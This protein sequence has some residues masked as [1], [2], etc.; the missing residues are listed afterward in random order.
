MIVCGGAIGSP[1]LLLLSGIGP[2]DDLRPLGIEVMADLP[3]V[4]ANLHD[5]FLATILYESARTI[6]EGKSRKEAAQHFAVPEGT[7]A[8]RLARARALLANRLRRRG[9][10]TK[11]H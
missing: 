9:V 10:N 3:G 1:Q 6:P 11:P 5:H 7:V 8:G 4:G 2:A